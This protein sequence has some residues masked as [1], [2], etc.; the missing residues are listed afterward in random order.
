MKL[1]ARSAHSPSLRLLTDLM[2]LLLAPT[3]P[4]LLEASAGIPEQERAA[5]QELSQHNQG[6]REL[7]QGLIQRR[8]GIPKRVERPA[9]SDEELYAAVGRRRL[10]QQPPD[11]ALH[12]E[13]ILGQVEKFQKELTT[14]DPATVKKIQEG[15]RKPDSERWEDQGSRQERVT[16]GSD[17][18]AKSQERVVEVRQVVFSEDEE[19]ETRAKILHEKVMDLIEHSGGPER[20]THHFPTLDVMHRQHQQQRQDQH[21][22]SGTNGPTLDNN[23]AISASQLPDGTAAGGPASS[24]GTELGLA[25]TTAS[26]PVVTLDPTY[27]AA[28]DKNRPREIVLDSTTLHPQTSQSSSGDASGQ[29]V[30]SE[31]GQGWGSSCKQ[32]PFETRLW[33][34][35]ITFS[36]LQTVD[37]RYFQVPLH[38]ACAARWPALAEFSAISH[39]NLT[40][41]YCFQQ[42]Q[43]LCWGTG[44]APHRYLM[45]H[46]CCSWYLPQ[47]LKCKGGECPNFQPCSAPMKTAPVAA[48]WN[49]HLVDGTPI[50]TAPPLNVAFQRDGASKL[51]SGGKDE[52]GSQGSKGAAGDIEDLQEGEPFSGQVRP[53]YTLLCR[54]LVLPG[55]LLLCGVC[56]C[57]N[58]LGRALL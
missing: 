31:G 18:E 42:L 5:N 20:S 43:V 49:S 33:V 28:S 6:P 12:G 26:G 38:L 57:P 14:S 29:W 23:A 35:N 16:P 3:L 4:L 22:H 19:P 52:A 30:D 7:R 45:G 1:R 36:K 27:A 53:W 40:A 9:A 25:G 15:T 58:L 51:G 11:L 47:G 2:L 24:S 21:V 46:T 48:C 13:S 10:Q 56:R 55:A 8:N 34:P 50:A 32:F 44:Y 39:N 54:L 37:L 41:I 17:E